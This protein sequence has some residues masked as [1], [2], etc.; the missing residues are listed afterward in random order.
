MDAGVARGSSCTEV[1]IVRCRVCSVIPIETN[2]RTFGWESV[3]GAQRPPGNLQV[4]GHGTAATP[5]VPYRPT[6]P[7]Q[8][9]GNAP[10]DV[11]QSNY[12]ALRLL[13]SEAAWA[14]AITGPPEVASEHGTGFTEE[15]VSAIMG[16]N[17]AGLLKL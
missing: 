17:A 6:V 13:L 5:G 7:G 3:G 9:R 11:G 4:A 12:P 16:D 1:G 14:K 8:H 15:E 10:R 2:L